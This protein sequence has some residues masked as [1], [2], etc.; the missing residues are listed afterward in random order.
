MIPSFKARFAIVSAAAA[1]LGLGACSD[2]ASTTEGSDDPTSSEVA[3]SAAPT[4]PLAPSNARIQRVH[5]SSVLPTEGQGSEA[6][7]GATKT[8]TTAHLNYYGG[9][10]IKN[11]KV[12]LVLWG[13]NVQY[14]TKLPAFYQWI[15]QSPYL[16]WQSEYNT[17]SPKQSIGLG[18]YLGSF[19]DPSPPSSTSITNAD[20]QTELQKLIED[21]T[22]PQ[23]DANTLYM[24]H[25]PPGVSIDLDG[26]GSC[27]VFCAYHNTMK[28][29]S[30][31][32]Y[33]GVMPDQGGACAG[34]CGGDADQFNNLTSVSSHEF[35]E[36]VTDPGVGLATGNAAPLAW[37][38]QTNGENGDI[39]VAE[40]SVIQGFTVQKLWSNK[41]NKCLDLPPNTPTDAGTD[42]GNDAG[43][44]AGNDAGGGNTC[45]HDIC[46]AGSKL[47]KS[48]DPCV[49]KIC[50]VD[51]Y[52]CKTKWDSECVDEVS[53]VC[54]QTCN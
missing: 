34:G 17:T 37:Y 33:Y 22:V 1:T 47:T 2:G 40:E 46:S 30:D 12:A 10:V 25:F 31:M 18:S 43:S 19:T 28:I 24:F 44:D 32:V 53:S 9:P 14:A 41:Y 42:S 23:N 15:V 21:G 4:T 8:A 20:I 13:D 26:S 54:D 11:V 3:R 6:S 5:R 39:C 38:D 29:G 36:A 35:S 16:A 48:C 52:C 27:E 7:K 49:T 50:K 51:S 45:S